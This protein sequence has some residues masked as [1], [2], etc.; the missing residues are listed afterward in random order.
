LE[1]TATFGWPFF[2]VHRYDRRRA[3]PSCSAFF[4]TSHLAP[5]AWLAFG[6]AGRLGFAVALHT[7]ASRG[8]TLVP[9]RAAQTVLRVRCRFRNTSAMRQAV[10][11]TRVPNRFIVPACLC[12]CARCCRAL[13]RPPREPQ[14]PGESSVPTLEASSAQVSGRRPYKTWAA[15]AAFRYERGGLSE[16]RGWAP[17]ALRREAQAHRRLC[18]ATHKRTEGP[19]PRHP[20]PPKPLRRDAQSPAASPAFCD[21]F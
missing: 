19:A 12:A 10:A 2:L 9:T 20:T 3:P 11:S 14:G 6:F 4:R 7:W 13:A 5:R 15:S 18:A 8:E 17:K 16:Q 21:D 1:R